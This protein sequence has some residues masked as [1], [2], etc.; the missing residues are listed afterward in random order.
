MSFVRWFG[1][2]DPWKRMEQFRREIDKLSAQMWS[3]ST[4]H[5]GIYPPMNIYEDGDGFLVRA[6]LAGVDPNSIDITVNAD[7]LTVSGERKSPLE[8]EGNCF[9]RRERKYG[10][11]QRAF[12]LT[13]QVDSENV[14]ATNRNGIL[15]IRM[16]RS[17]K[18]KARKVQIH[19]S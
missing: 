7:T 19:S 17:E 12:T 3:P 8:A 6:E 10:K 5:R 16:P 13:E 11:F 4:P 15:E 2:N 14:S 9:H 18:S 1:D